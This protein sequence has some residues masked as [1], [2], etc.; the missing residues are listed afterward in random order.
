MKALKDRDKPASPRLVS[1]A[2]AA[3]MLGG[4]NILTLDKM[5]ERG[6]VKSL[7][8]GDRVLIKTASIDK[9]TAA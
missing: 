1:R 7:R 8:I 5:I 3:K 6:E 4:I 9:L 2:E